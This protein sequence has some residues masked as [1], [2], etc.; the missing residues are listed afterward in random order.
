MGDKDIEEAGRDIGRRGLRGRNGGGGKRRDR[1]RRERDE[2]ER[3]L[4]THA[5]MQAHTQG[6][7][8]AHT[9]KLG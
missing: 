4:R 6:C 2:G 9:Y 1:A 8:S 7:A 3:W 5:I